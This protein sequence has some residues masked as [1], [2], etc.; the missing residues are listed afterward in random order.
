MQTVHINLVS[1]QLL[2]NLI[3]TFADNQCAGVVLVLG[4]STLSERADRLESLYRGRD[5]SVFW[6]SE[7]SSSHRLQRL[8]K[9]ATELLAWLEREQGDKNWVL[10][11]TCGTKPMALAFANAFNQYNASRPG[12]PPKALILYTDSQN[13]EIPLLNEGVDFALPWRPVLTL[14]E[15]LEAN[16]FVI[17]WCTDSSNDQDVHERAQ[18]T[19]HLGKQFQ[20]S[21][22]YFLGSLQYAAAITADRY[23]LNPIG[24]LNGIP[25]QDHAK[26]CQRLMEE[27]LLS[28][29]G[30]GKQLHFASEDACRYLGGRW[31]EELAYLAALECGFE[32]VAMGVEGIWQDKPEPVAFLR[33]KNN[34]FDLLI[35]H[36][37]QLLTI[38]CKA[39]H[40][41][42]GEEGGTNNQDVLH[43]LDN[44]SR[45]LGGLYGE[46]ML[47]SAQ[48]LTD[49]MRQRANDNRITLCERADSRAILQTL[50]RYFNQMN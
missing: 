35:C 44:L 45:K 50:Q 30:E 6:R 7:G 21:C 39:K 4:D 31:L 18:L 1:D 41:G 46:R 24:E 3:P 33:G 13:R 12:Q 9:Q 2:P 43:K 19:R 28:W 22:R 37:N 5:I 14:E 38:E 47:I 10:N 49:A 32:Q 36:H 11:A 27:G 17:T 16:G 34:E 23:A 8:Q 42:N 26:L 40:W 29:D 15:I 20:G 48:A 25:K